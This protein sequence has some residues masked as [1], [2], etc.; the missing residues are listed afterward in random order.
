MSSTQVQ[1]YAKLMKMASDKIAKLEA[2]LDALKSKDKSEPIAIIGMGCR[3]PGGASTPEA[4]WDIL[5][6]GVDAITEVPQDRWHL[7][8]YYDP[9]PDSPGKIYTRYGGFLNKLQEFDNN[10]FGISPKEAIHLDPQQRLLLEVSWE[11]LENSGKNPQ[12]LQGSPTG[13]FIGICGNDYTQRIF[14]QGPEQ[15]DAY[16]ATGN[17]HSTASGRISYILGLIGPNLAVDTACSSS[18]V[19]IHLACSSLRNQEC[20]LALSG[21]V[22]LLLSQEFSINF[23]KA[24]MLSFDGRCKT[25][26]TSADGFVRGEGCGIVVLKRLSDAVAD[27]D[28]ILA[29]IRG[30]AINQDGDTSGLTVPNGPSQQSVI[31]QALANGEVDPTSVS[32]LEAHGTGT[33]LGDP[34]EVEAI[35]TVFGKTHSVE[36]PLII[37]SVK[38]NIGHTEGAAGIAGLLKLVLQLQHQQ[39]APSLHFNQPNPY[40]NWSQLPVKVSTQLTPWQTNEKSRIAGVSSFGF[41]GTNAHVILEEA[42]IEGNRQQAT[43]NSEDYR[44]GNSEDYLERSVHLL[45]LSAKTETAFDELVS[46][47]QNYLPTHPELGVGDICYTAN[48]GRAHFNHRLAVIAQNQQELVE[49]LREHQEGEEVAGIFSG[50]LPNNTT[51][52][53]IALLFTG[54]GSQ[55]VN[56]GRQLYQQAATFREAIN[57]CDDILKTVETFRDK[58]LR[59]I[60]YPA[61]DSSDSSLLNQTAY[62]Q[63]VLF[64][65]E[66]ALCQLWQSWGIKPNA[67][68]GHSVGEYVAATVAG[69]FS[70]EDALKLIAARGRLMQKLPAGGEMVSVMAPEV[71]VLETLNGM[72]LGDKVA[73]AAINGPQSIVIS[74][75]SEAVRAI[76]TNLESLG[77]KTKQL[78]VSHAFHSPLMEPMLAEFEAVA[79]QITYHQPRILLISNV[80]GKLVGEEITSAKY[81][82]N[83]VRQPVRFAQSMTTLHQQG[84]ELFL[85]IGPKP[86]L[87]GMGR[88]CLLEEVGVWLPSLRPG[89]DEWQQMLSSLG[90]LYVQGVKIDWLGFDKDYARQKVALPTYPFQGERYWVETKVNGNHQHSSW[91]SENSN[92]A[93]VNLLSQ[94]ETATLAQQLEQAAKFS[95]EQLKLLPEILEVLAK[96]HQQQLAA[97]TIKDWFYQLQWQPLPQT[98]S[99]T[100]IKPSHWLI[101]ADNTGVAEK[102]AQKLQEQGHECSLV[103]RADNYQQLAAG[104]YQLNPSA[105]E[106]FEQLQKF[107]LETSQLSLSK[108]IHLWSLDAPATEDL[109]LDSLE[110]TQLWGC[111]SVLHLLQSVLKTTNVPQLWLVTR[112]AQSVLSNTEK[113]TV[114]ASPLW[115]LG[116]VVS[117]ENSQLW[118]GLVDLDP[119]TPEDEV[120]KLLQLLVNNLEE[121]HLALRGE[122]TYVARLVQQSPQ[123]S[124]QPLSLS[125]DATYLITGGLGAL[126]LH[127]AQWL[128]EKGARNIVLTGRSARS[129]TVQEITEQLE[130]AGAQVRV[131]LGDISVE[132]DVAQIIEE[133]QISLPTLKGVIHAAGVLDDATLQQMSWEHFTK[134]MAPKVRGTWHLHQF[135]QDLPLDFFVCFSSMASLIGSPGQGNY[136]AANAFMDALAHYRR[137]RGL[138]GLSINWS[139]WSY[140]GMAASLAVEH[141]NRI[142]N[143]GISTIAPEQGMYA[144]EEMLRNQALTGQVGVISVQWSL[145]T[146]Q[147]SNLNKSSLL[148]QLLQQEQSQQPDTHEQQLNREILEK[149]EKASPGERQEIL[150]KHIRGQVAKVLGFNSSQL[151]EV[152]LGFMEMGMDSLTTVELKNRLQAQLGIA[153]PGTVAMEYPTIETLSQYILKE[154]MGW[155]SVADSENNLP[156]LE[157]VDVDD[158]ILPVIENISEEEFEALAAQQLEKIKSML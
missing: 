78:Q 77:I 13:V 120:E 33:A 137:G 65:I 119:Q 67:V 5:Q 107:I 133:I 149:L 37:G 28:N 89:V 76:A 25:F 55:Y 112:G 142:H 42:P 48:T 73:I 155:Q 56:M 148:R 98:Q 8:D 145:L 72:S 141:Q 124:E 53:K 125:S 128:V 81:W 43:G 88:Q 47:Y 63:P 44:K 157:E 113:L 22:N 83:H 29:V 9:D 31:R 21:G 41:S 104:R 106:E 58:S 92:T 146:Q 64:A 126:G 7:D 71:K 70:L 6:N 20:N 23:S 15:F 39:I 4:F 19:S 2:E 79:N 115:G 151:P 123:S 144:L 127:T 117:L 50:K 109:T 97:A 110:Q 69:V 143:L 36:Q 18:L 100:S 94:G 24:R 49:K 87:L 80:T 135:T 38:T 147:W 118:R 59:E 99:Q 136:A 111:G 17:A 66:Y 51:A 91:T 86:V 32:Y 129:E 131:L 57:Q 158:H 95:P 61:D 108:V 84:Y 85:E 27:Q 138:S 16:V 62:T 140:G 30:S 75:D 11:A 154:V 134:V 3:F 122:Q 1:E 52:P 139:A 121:D 103:H 60:L 156:E 150:R 105:P 93:I 35:G 116:R 152:N 54:Q 90:Q 130:Q 46:S 74:G 40:I 96:Q 82:V 14:S 153:L 114:A 102:L 68:M 45:T 101:F 10:F 26:D 34:I 12:Q 132:Q